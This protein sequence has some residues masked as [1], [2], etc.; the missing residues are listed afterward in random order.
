MT[1]T[2][3]CVNTI[4][5]PP[6]KQVCVLVWSIGCYV[7]S[8]LIDS[9]DVGDTF[10]FPSVSPLSYPSLSE[11]FLQYGSLSRSDRHVSELVLVFVAVFNI[12]F[13]L[14][15]ILISYLFIFITILKIPSVEG[16]LKAI[17]TCAS[18]LTAVSIFYGTVI[19]MYSQPTSNHSMDT[20]KIISVF[21]TVIIPMLNPMV[22]S[23]R[24]KEV[25][26][27]FKKVV[28]KVKLSLSFTS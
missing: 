13:A 12:F 10:H 1:A 19:F 18:D 23:L 26:N 21:Y 2:Q 9:F 11:L 5:P 16:Y 27:A 28:E 20:D 6:W 4:A 24:N 22:Y 8:F 17:S 14:L 3:Q 15:I 7:C 25:K